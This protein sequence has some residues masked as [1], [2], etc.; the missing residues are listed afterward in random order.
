MIAEERGSMRWPATYHQR[1]L[2]TEERF[3]Q[4]VNKTSTCWLWVGAKDSY[5][6]G[7]F[8]PGGRQATKKA[9]RWAYETLIGPIPPGLELDHLC[10]VRACVNPTHLEAVTQRENLLRSPLVVTTRNHRATYCKRG[11]EFSEVNTYITKQG[12]RCRICH[13][14][15]SRQYWLAKPR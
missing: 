5:G 10:R 15:R 1:F 9:H 7:H 2:S 11:H 4:K 6:Y 3:W 14:A 13:L 12:R 8:R